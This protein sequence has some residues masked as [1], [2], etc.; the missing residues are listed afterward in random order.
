MPRQCSRLRVYVSP[1]TRSH[2]RRLRNCEL[3]EVGSFPKKP[4]H[5]KLRLVHFSGAS[6]LHPVRWVSITESCKCLVNPLSAPGY[7]LLDDRVPSGWGSGSIR[8]K[9]YSS[10]LYA[11]CSPD[12]ARQNYQ[13][14]NHAGSKPK[15][16]PN[17]VG[18]HVL[19]HQR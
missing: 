3:C 8:A 12:L 15:A 13:A 16:C 5:S 6:R 7:C 18:N 14:S 9:N 4:H 11:I 1:L 19:V 10:V 2:S 17:S